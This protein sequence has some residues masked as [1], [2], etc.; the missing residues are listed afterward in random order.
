MD[1]DDIDPYDVLEEDDDFEQRYADEMDYEEDLID[2]TQ[3]PSQPS[4][5]NIQSVRPST[6]AAILVLLRMWIT[7]T[8]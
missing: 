5:K 1:Y 4:I 7:F 2:A 3:N 8:L 6:T